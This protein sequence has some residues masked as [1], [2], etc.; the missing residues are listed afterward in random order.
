MRDWRW[1]VIVFSLG[2]MGGLGLLPR[3]DDMR[4][5]WCR[6]RS[7]QNNNRRTA[8]P[9]TAPPILT[10]AIA[11]L[12]K[13]SFSLSPCGNDVGVGVWSVSAAPLVESAVLGPTRIHVLES[14]THSIERR[15]SLLEYLDACGKPKPC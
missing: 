8:K 5:A 4:F 1:S 6:R 13:E 2:V 3:T 14:T 7:S 10:P 11:V 12:D 9:A 15:N